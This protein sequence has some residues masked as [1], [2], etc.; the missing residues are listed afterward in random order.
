[1]TAPE[2]TTQTRSTAPK[3]LLG[4]SD[5]DA[6]LLSGEIVGMEAEVPQESALRDFGG[7]SAQ[8]LKGDLVGLVGGMSSQ[9]LFQSQW[10]DEAAAAVARRVW[11][12]PR[13][14]NAVFPDDVRDALPTVRYFDPFGELR[15]QTVFDDRLVR[16]RCDFHS[17]ALSDLIDIELIISSVQRAVRELVDVF[18]DRT[19][20][21]VGYVHAGDAKDTD[22]DLESTGLAY[23]DLLG[24]FPPLSREYEDLEIVIVGEDEIKP[25]T[26][27]AEDHQVWRT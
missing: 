20:G 13:V 10:R 6:P 22:D 8:L 4:W 9:P 3:M 19:A 18:L 7:M 14:V 16:V 27:T 26:Y 24:D 21:V 17:S 1:M 23:T 5:D 25:R 12:A 15:A 2:K 11:S